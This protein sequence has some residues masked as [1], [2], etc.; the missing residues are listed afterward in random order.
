M[1]KVF[2]D[3]EINRIINLY[4]KDGLNTVE[5]GARLGVSSTPIKR[6]LKEIGM[7]KKGKSN[8]IK[9]SL[10]S[11][12]E[13]KIKNLYLKQYKSCN[14]IGKEMGLTASFVDKYLSKCEFRRDKG[15]AASIG[16]VKRYHNMDYN[17]YL[18]NIDIYYKYELEVF[19][20]TRQQMI[21]NLPNY[22]NRGNS[23]VDGA[24]HLDHK[25]SIIEGFK[26]NIKPEIIGNIKNLEFIPWEENIK[27]RT[28]CSITIEELISN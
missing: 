28:K 3:T 27:K 19:R 8:G 13:K 25:F 22:K 26:N 4:T 7:L 9:I 10:T 16:L 1:K 15:K 23:G 14:E 24:Y 20:V 12:Q 11:G 18:D 17:E 5:I 6:T 21:K 2:T